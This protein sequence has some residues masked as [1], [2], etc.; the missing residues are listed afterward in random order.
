MSDRTIACLVYDDMTLL[1]L[2]GPLQVLKPLEMVGPYRVVTV[3][4]RAGAAVTTDAGL[5]VV[6]GLSFDDVP[7]PWAVLVPGGMLGPI[8]AMVDERLMA[9]LRRAAAEA[10][11]VTSVCTGALILA[12]AGLLEG[13]KATTHWSFLEAL[14]RFGAQPTRGRWVQDG[15]VI[16][17]AGVSAGIDMALALVAQLAGEPTARMIQVMIEYDPEPPL[18]PIDW[19]EFDPGVLSGLADVAGAGKIPDILADRPDLLEK[20]TLR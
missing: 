11:L 20:L 1:D 8:R 14:A 18:G 3:G 5:S 6:P 17:A 16:T 2:V 10:E 9:W 19:D 4:R 7:E 13:R 15:K 12:A